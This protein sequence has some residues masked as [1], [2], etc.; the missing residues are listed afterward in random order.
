M[1]NIEAESSDEEYYPSSIKNRNSCPTKKLASSSKWI[2]DKNIFG[3]GSQGSPKKSSKKTSKT[4]PNGTLGHVNQGRWSPE[5]HKKF[6]E[7][8]EL[9]GRDWK[10]VQDYVGTRTSTQAR[11]HA[12][13]VLPH[14]NWADGVTAS[15]N[16]TSTTLTK[17]S[18]QNDKIEATP[19]FK[20]TQS[21]ASD[22]NNSEFAIFKVEKVR[23][24]K[25]GRDRVYSEN[26]VFRSSEDDTDFQKDRENRDRGTY[27]KNSMN[28]E[29]NNHKSD[30][31]GS[32]I[33]E[34]IKEQFSEDE[35]EE[36]KEDFPTLR[37]E[38]HKTCDPRA[39]DWF[40]GNPLFW[41][42]NKTNDLNLDTFDKECSPEFPMDIDDGLGLLNSL[43]YAKGY[44]HKEEKDKEMEPN[45]EDSYSM[46]VEIED[47][48]YPINQN[49]D[50]IASCHLN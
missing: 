30:L 50:N 11:S 39:L 47:N 10:K 25:V 24:N 36:G 23:T 8:I 29:F 5:E 41:L 4:K 34:A 46:E 19:E 32:P 6:L 35:E 9:Y 31:I 3:V 20:K 1:S 28:V 15:H 33:K 45:H 17:G 2:V 38:K 27:R 12:Q 48:Y 16:S 22:E 26:N 18:P 49:F 42:N 43:T 37:F 7:A 40:D 44:L 13:K 21:F 14:P